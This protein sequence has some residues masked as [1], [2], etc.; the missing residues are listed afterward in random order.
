MKL[1]KNMKTIRFIF[2]ILLIV[3]ISGPEVL[4]QRRKG[5]VSGYVS[6][7]DSNKPVPFLTV[8][9]KNSTKGTV[10][11]AEGFFNLENINPGS[12]ELVF[13]HLSYV[14]HKEKISVIKG[15]K[16]EINVSLILKTIDIDEV[17]KTPDFV[18]WRKNFRTFKRIFLGSVANLSVR[19]KNPEDMFFYYNPENKVLS[20]FADKPL[21]IINKVLGY[22]I[23]YQLDFF[24]Y[25]EEDNYYT[26]NGSA[27]YEDLKPGIFLQEIN[28]RK[29]REACYNGSLMQF[30]RCL[31]DTT[32]IGKGY[33][34]GGVLPYNESIN[35]GDSIIIEDKLANNFIADSL[36]NTDSLNITE[37]KVYSYYSD[38]P[39]AEYV[40]PTE[41]LNEKRLQFAELLNVGYGYNLSGN[42]WN[43]TASELTLNEDFIMFDMNGNIYPPL[44]LVSHGLFASKRNMRYMLPV[45]YYPSEKK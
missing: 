29:N 37:K 28:W 24:K 33:S 32:Y 4:A 2:L 41:N 10:T 43:D 35:Q 1:I 11:N 12:Y 23:S 38:L 19:L 26:F 40:F 5:R 22:K 14:T 30:L 36:G 13:Q 15:K 16:I 27:Y 21:I 31:Y 20:G 17:V 45:D 3:L 44:G 6:D 8:F 34:V 42:Y 39:Y 7:A 18:N 25:F 9:I